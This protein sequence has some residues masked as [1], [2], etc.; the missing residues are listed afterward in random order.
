[1]G[2]DLDFIFSEIET[3]QDIIL[4]FKRITSAPEWRRNCRELGVEAGRLFMVL[5]NVSKIYKNSM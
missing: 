5:N 2:I 3:H 4:H 1:M